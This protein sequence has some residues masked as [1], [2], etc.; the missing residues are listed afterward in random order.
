MPSS[1]SVWPAASV[2]RRRNSITLLLLLRSSPLSAV[3]ALRCSR[4]MEWYTVPCL[5]K[6][7]ANFGTSLGDS[8]RDWILYVPLV[9]MQLSR[10][11]C[12]AVTQWSFSAAVSQPR[13]K[14]RS[15]VSNSKAYGVDCTRFTSVV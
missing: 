6:L 10:A 3:A 5:R 2:S 14:V 13:A 9:M 12:S 11:T 15:A 7:A 4:Q 8:S 1:K